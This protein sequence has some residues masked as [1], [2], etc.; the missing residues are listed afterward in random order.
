MTSAPD[1][2]WGWMIVFAVF[3]GNFIIDGVVGCF[4]FFYPALL[5]A[6][7][8]SPAVTSMS[9]S[10]IVGVYLATAP[11]VG[12][13]IRRFGCRWV[14]F[15]GA[16]V[17]TL[18]LCLATL[19]NNI[20]VFMIA[21]GGLGG[22]GVGMNSLCGHLIVN[23][24]F[25]KRRGLAGG[26]VSAGA[27]LGVFVMAP[28]TQHVIRTY[29]WRGGL[30]LTSGV[31]LQFCVFALLM[32][33]LEVLRSSPQS[34]VSNTT[35]VSSADQ[36]QDV[37][38][39]DGHQDVKQKQDKVNDDISTTDSNGT[40]NLASKSKQKHLQNPVFS[41]HRSINHFNE[42]IRVSN[43][44][45]LPD[46]SKM[47]DK[48][49]VSKSKLHYRGHV[50]SEGKPRRHFDPLMRKDIF[51][52]GNLD[53]LKEFQQSGS[54]ETFVHSMIIEASDASTAEEGESHMT[55]RK[56]GMCNW[57]IFSNPV[58]IPMLIGGALIQ[59][60]QFIPSTFLPE[61][62]YTVGL[63]RPDASIVIALYGALNIAGRLSAGCLA[64]LNS[65]NPLFLCNFGM[66]MSAITCAL[67]PLCRTFVTL[68]LFS[69][70]FG[71]FI[72]Y[73]PPLQVL[74]L[75]RYLGL[76]KLTSAMGFIQLA[77][78][79]AAL[80]GP[81]LAGIIYEWT[82]DY[83]M[84]MEFAAIV[85]FLSAIIPSLVPVIYHFSSPQNQ[86]KGPEMEIIVPGN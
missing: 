30:L 32:R 72:G 24:Y 11:L 35:S 69:S 20:Y 27:G 46:L 77:K 26:I 22:V 14:S 18:G 71:Y 40:V 33:P 85:F 48:Q 54:V 31:T 61:Y 42:E 13:L 60:G 38:V 7:H 37:D 3:M 44:Y 73:F 10:L 83:A 25:S 84:S 21:Y 5:D 79:P 86:D 12:I 80:V 62:C 45:S 58:Y 63:S 28:F 1:G 6:F 70:C 65:I 29:G 56:D 50:V 64:N 43:L 9:G 49:F 66:L 41:S 53:H 51:Y 81:P 57:S 16:L 75:V 23:L 68:C 59:M 2:G 36:L 17:A 52:S 4:G 82:R 19:S 15:A 8:A 47:Q 55:G 74:A 34:T 76:E 39:N 78:G 67:F